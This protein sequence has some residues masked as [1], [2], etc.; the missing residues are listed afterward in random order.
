MTLVRPLGTILPGAVA[1]MSVVPR[2]AQAIARQNKAMTVIEITRRVG[3]GGVSVISRA[4]GK[5]ASSY[6]RR[7]AAVCGN[8]TTFLTDF[9]DTS[10]QVVE[11]GVAAVAANQLIMGSVLNDAAALDGDNAVGVAYR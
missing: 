1:T 2:E 8:G 10:L 3:D 5:N 11:F 9:M 4:A 6:S 7:R